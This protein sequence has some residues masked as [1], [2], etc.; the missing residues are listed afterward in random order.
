M[1]LVRLAI[2]RMAM[3]T[4]YWCQLWLQHCRNSTCQNAIK[5]A[6]A[7]SPDSNWTD[8]MIYQRVL[9]FLHNF[10]TQVARWSVSVAGNLM[11]KRST[12]LLKRLRKIS[13]SSST[14]PKIND[15]TDYWKINLVV[16]LS[17]QKRTVNRGLI[18]EDW[19]R[20]AI[21]LVHHRA[22]LLSPN[23]LDRDVVGLYSRGGNK[24]SINVNSAVILTG[25]LEA[26]VFAKASGA[27]SST[28]TLFLEQHQDAVQLLDELWWRG[29]SEAQL[30]L[31]IGI[32][33][34][35][36]LEQKSTKKRRN[37]LKP[38]LVPVAL[39]AQT[40]LGLM[41]FPEVKTG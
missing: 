5:L 27:G 13:A 40:Q 31:A 25:K 22:I 10:Q 6:Q 1:P 7:F 21:E 28:H 26:I 12:I 16:W 24:C 36:V 15:W 3:L 23:S 2:F 8:E 30:A 32:W 14:I 34:V 18:M 20:I 38:Q 17:I 33:A 9:D 19:K 29:Q 37:G 39:E 35:M 11:T 4:R 41:W